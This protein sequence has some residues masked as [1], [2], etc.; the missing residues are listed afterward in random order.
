M[1][2]QKTPKKHIGISGS[3]LRQPKALDRLLL[4]SGLSLIITM[5]ISLG[6]V[7]ATVVAA[8]YQKSSIPLL[9]ELQRQPTP[10]IQDSYQTVDDNL[11][12]N[13]LVSDLPLFVFWAVVGMV[14][15]S[16]TTSSL[17]TLAKARDFREQLDY[18]HADREKLLRQAKLQLGIRAAILLVWFFFLSYSKN[19]ILPYAV[20]V[21]FAATGPVGWAMSIGYFIWATALLAACLHIHTIFLRLLALRPRLFEVV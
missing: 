18:V 3:S 7:T 6:I 8:Q 17:N 1:E 16:F 19:A 9:V 10:T 11:S 5:V 15:Y 13:S 14:V 12:T 20:A 2:P 4:P 21:A